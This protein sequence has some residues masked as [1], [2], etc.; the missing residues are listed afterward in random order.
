M[1]GSEIVFEREWGRLAVF[2]ALTLLAK[3]GKLLALAE[4]AP[5]GRFAFAGGF[6]WPSSSSGEMAPVA[7]ESS[8]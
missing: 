6:L 2:V 7:D 5:V 1:P 3:F 8:E 4:R